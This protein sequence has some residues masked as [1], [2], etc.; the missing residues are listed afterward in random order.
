MTASQQNVEDQIKQLKVSLENYWRQESMVNR[1]IQECKKQLEGLE[2][3]LKVIS[4][5]P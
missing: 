1:R 3:M 5:A 4:D 2:A